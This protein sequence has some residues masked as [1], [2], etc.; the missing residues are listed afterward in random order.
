MP[1]SPD[2]YRALTQMVNSED[3]AAMVSAAAL[4]HLLPVD[5]EL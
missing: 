3:M 4:T 5:A 1:M 2:D